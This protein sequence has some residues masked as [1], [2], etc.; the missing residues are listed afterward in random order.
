M[1]MIGIDLHKRESQICIIDESGVVQEKR[2][3]TSRERFSAVLGGRPRAKVLI[4]ASTESEWAARHIESLN[5]EV[6]VADPNFA[7]M[8][9]RRSRRIKTDK[10]DARTLAEALRMGAYRSAHRLSDKRRHI[11]A[12]LAVR[13]ALVR[14]RTRYIAVAK[15]L[16]R[17]DG[18]RVV[19]SMSRNTAQRISELP[20]SEQLS[21]ELRPLLDILEPINMEIDAA[22]FRITQ[23]MVGDSAVKLVATVPQVGPLTA[24]AV[25][26]TVDDIGRFHSSEQFAAYL[27]LVPREK[28]SGE[29]LSRGRITKAGNSRC[30]T[31]LVEAALRIMISKSDDTAAL[32][33]WASRIAAKRGKKI[34]TVALARRFATIIYAVWKSGEMYDSRKLRGLTQEEKAG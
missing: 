26:A 13:E 22:D 31:L 23:L 15:S 4:E 3:V 18:Y 27:G 30:R 20:L 29:K 32:R 7:P 25:V 9:A 34:A 14:T 11:R 28:S 16:L 21:Q 10:R 17:R 2:I 5:H 8:Y 1:E 33:S 12:E 19:S 24:S 6:V